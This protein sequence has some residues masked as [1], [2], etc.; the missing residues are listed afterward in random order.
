MFCKIPAL[1]LCYL[2]K[3]YLCGEC[4]VRRLRTLYSIMAQRE[5]VVEIL[6]AYAK[7]MDASDEVCQAELANLSYTLSDQKMSAVL[8]C[9]AT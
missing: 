5:F 7:R 6:S 2:C 9:D 1:F 4:N 3:K 8:A